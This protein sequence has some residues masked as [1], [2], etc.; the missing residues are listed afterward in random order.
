MATGLMLVFEETEHNM[1]G[2]DPSDSWSRDSWDRD[3]TLVKVWM[4]DPLKQLAK[5]L[6]DDE[7]PECDVVVGT[8]VL[9]GDKVYI[10]WTEYSTG[11]SFGNDGG[12][13]EVVAAFV[14]EER[15]KKCALDCTNFAEKET[16]AYWDDS[17]YSLHVELD[18][19]TTYKFHVPWLGYFERLEEVHVSEMIIEAE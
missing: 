4:K 1:G 12:Q 6:K 7:C 11:D 14:D 13:R 19:G 15:A 3:N 16:S 10:V 8:E 9:P 17:R 5:V 18:N 2:Y